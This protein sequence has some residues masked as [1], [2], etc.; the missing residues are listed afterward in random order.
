[1]PHLLQASRLRIH[2]DALSKA[3]AIGSSMLN[4]FSF[5]ILAITEK[6]RVVF[7]N[8]VADG[9][10]CGKK[11][12]QAN[13][14][15]DNF[16]EINLAITQIC[17]QLFRENKRHAQT[18]LTQSGAV[19]G[20]LL[21][22]SLP[23]GHPVGAGFT[24]RVALVISR[25]TKNLAPNA[26]QIFKD[27]FGLTPAEIRLSE[28]LQ[29]CD[30]LNDAADIL[31]ITHGTAKAQLKSIFQKTNCHSQAALRQLWLELTCFFSYQH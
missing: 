28:E 15:M 10:L 16:A 23:E 6:A 27:L 21:G 19:G 26:T 9:W 13:Q 22:L 31:F 20:Y 3:A 30:R 24:E 29:R 2:F 11:V 7:A 1:M 17:R 12:L 5:P 14:G 18:K 8:T 25:G 4:S